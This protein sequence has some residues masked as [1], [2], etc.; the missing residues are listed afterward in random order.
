MATRNL[1]LYPALCADATASFA[2]SSDTINAVVKVLDD[3]KPQSPGNNHGVG[4][5]DWRPLLGRL[6]THEQR[7]LQITA[8]WHLERIRWQSI[9]PNT[10]PHTERL[11]R[12]GIQSLR[13]QLDGCV[14]SINEVLDELQSALLDQTEEGQE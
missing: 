4:G 14:D 11:L 1:S 10:D 6:Q 2:V 8:A 5:G 9:D 7:K 12:D 3:D 13:T